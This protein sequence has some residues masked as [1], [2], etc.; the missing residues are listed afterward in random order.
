M[1]PVIQR[2]DLVY[3][4]V[5]VEGKKGKEGGIK[6]KFVTNIYSLRINNSLPTRLQ[7]NQFKSLFVCSILVLPKGLSHPSFFV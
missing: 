3:L 5:N 6:M 7:S 1:S 4:E 2:E